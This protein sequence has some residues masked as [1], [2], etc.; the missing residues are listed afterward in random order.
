MSARV[1][2]LLPGLEAHRIEAIA[3]ADATDIEAR[4]CRAF[5][6]ALVG[7]TEEAARE[8]HAVQREAAAGQ[9]GDLVCDAVSARALAAANAADLDAATELA[10]RA[11]MMA[12]TEAL[13]DQEVTAHLV[14]ARVRR[15]T[16][17]PFLATRI[18]SALQR[19][20][21]GDFAAWIDWELVMAAGTTASLC[22]EGAAATF[23]AALAAAR[24]GDADGMAKAL[25]VVTARMA[26]LSG[27][28][29]DVRS[30]RALLDGC[31]GGAQLDPAVAAFRAGQRD[32]APLGLLGLAAGPDSEARV[33]VFVPEQGRAMR[34]LAL[35]APIAE[36]SGATR[37]RQ[38]QRKQGR[39]DT[40]LA[41]LALAGA[42]LSEDALFRATYGFAFSSNVH[43]GVLEVLLHRARA[44]LGDAAEI[45]RA[46]GTLALHPR[47]PL[48]LADPRCGGS[49]ED[50]ILQLVARQGH[51]TAKEASRVLDVPLRSAQAAL[52]SLLG[53]GCCTRE[54]NGRAIEYRVDDTTFREPTGVGGG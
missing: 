23:A 54:R 28:H 52:E 48:L 36:R 25:D 39:V 42:G 10:R 46:S 5:A 43:A 49:A 50:R 33:V 20:A 51:T 34:L 37:L 11:S 30:A 1:R 27:Q 8:A 41:A 35:A 40:V 16:G 21:P 13:R 32:E 19:Y 3:Q 2:D 45:V 17:R 44:H 29:S 15:L 22:P 24:A 6:A 7:R 26:G 9:R 38:S 14:L 12:R 53:S 18:L 47:R 31:D 4:V